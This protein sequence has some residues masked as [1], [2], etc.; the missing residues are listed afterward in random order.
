MSYIP[1]YN[2]EPNFMADPADKREWDRYTGG[3]MS[4]KEAKKYEQMRKEQE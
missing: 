3:L 4:E 1:D 2:L